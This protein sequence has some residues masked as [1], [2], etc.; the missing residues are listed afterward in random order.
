MS[1]TSALYA[2]GFLVYLAIG[3]VTPLVP[4]FQRNLE[5]SIADVSVVIAAFGLARV[6]VDVP[7]AQLGIRFGTRPLLAADSRGR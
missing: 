7:V 5:A 1:P 4:E 3:S 6:C 2:I